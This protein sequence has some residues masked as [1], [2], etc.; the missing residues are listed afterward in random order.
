MQPCFIAERM[1]SRL[2]GNFGATGPSGLKKF[3]KS[4]VCEAKN[5]EEPY[6]DDCESMVA[7]FLVAC[8]LVI[9]CCLFGVGWRGWVDV[10]CGVVSFALTS[11]YAVGL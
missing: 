10:P 8:G 7:S 6:D 11:L 9:P 5:G 2:C 4:P 1:K 3:A